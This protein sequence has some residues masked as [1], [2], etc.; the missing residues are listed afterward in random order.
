MTPVRES[1]QVNER[2]PWPVETRACVC[3]AHGGI[4]WMT[5]EADD[6]WQGGPEDPPVG[7][8]KGT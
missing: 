3:G 7:K 2:G 5:D 6:A 4:D 1:E 8:A